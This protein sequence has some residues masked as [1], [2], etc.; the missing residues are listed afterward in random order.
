MRAPHS[1]RKAPKKSFD[2]GAGR[3]MK[4]EYANIS[5]CSRQ[6]KG[7]GTI[8]TPI[9]RHLPPP[10]IHLLSSTS[11]TSPLSPFL[12]TH[13]SAPPPL[14]SASSA[15]AV[16][17]CCCC[18]LPSCLP[19]TTRCCALSCGWS[20]FCVAQCIEASIA[21]FYRERQS[22]EHPRGPQSTHR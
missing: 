21:H 17:S 6:D 20:S 4:V 16:Q 13:P 9:L 2:R 5:L 7:P 14:L 1:D 12:S 8:V 22:V 3:D 11:S 10:L 15:E 19:I 18:G